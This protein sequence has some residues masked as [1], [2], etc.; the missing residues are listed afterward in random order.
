MARPVK[1][2]DPSKIELLAGC[3]C[4]MPEIASK[5]DCSISTLEKKYMDSVL[6]GR[7]IGKQ[8]IRGKQFELAMKGNVTML[9]WLGKQLLGQ[10]DSIKQTIDINTLT[11]EQALAILAASGDTEA[12]SRVKQG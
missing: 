6:K 4:T 7:D 2:I 10:T 9:I 11:P 1:E 8:S 5:L 3:G 12:N